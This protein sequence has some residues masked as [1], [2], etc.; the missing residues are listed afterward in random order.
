[1]TSQAQLQ[2]YNFCVYQEKDFN[3]GIVCN[4]NGQTIDFDRICE[5][6]RENSILKARLLVN[7]LRYE[8]TN[9]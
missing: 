3:L 8:L 5:S 6:Y 7:S 4:L 2:F 9:N 1:M